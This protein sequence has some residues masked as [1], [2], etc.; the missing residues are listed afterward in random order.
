MKVWLLNLCV[1]GRRDDPEV[2]RQ[3][4]PCE[5]A[6][7]AE[8]D[9]DPDPRFTMANERTFLAWNRT[10]LAFIAGGLAIEQFLDVGRAPRLLVSIPLICLG[11]FVGVAGYWR[12][13]ASEDAMRAGRPVGES[14]VPLLLAGAMVLLAAAAVA[15][16]IASTR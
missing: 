15:L 13:R 14:G 10:A 4:D 11:G 9:A 8:P 5:H 1:V 3:E 12:W 6:R 2:V 7:M 16:V